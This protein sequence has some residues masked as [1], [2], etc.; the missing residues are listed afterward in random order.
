MPSNVYGWRSLPDSVDAGSTGSNI[1]VD[2]VQV[3][4]QGKHSEFT[5]ALQCNAFNIPVLERSR[6]LSFAGLK[7]EDFD[8]TS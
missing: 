8:W 4:V 1:P 2:W 5:A 3:A 7:A 6:K